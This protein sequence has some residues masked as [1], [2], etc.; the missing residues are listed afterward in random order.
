G[1]TEMRGH[2]VEYT[3]WNMDALFIPQ[4]HPARDLQDTFYLESKFK[5]EFEHPEILDIVSRSHERGVRSY[6]G[7]GY[8]FNLKEAQRLVLRTHT[9][10]STIRS[11]YENH[12]PPVAIFSVEKVFRHESVD[13]RHL[14]ELHQVEGAV[15]AK[16]ANLSTL[17]GLMRHFYHE[18]GFDDLEF[19]PSYYP[20]TEPSMDVVATLDEKEI[21]LGGS[22]IFRPEVTIPVG[23]KYPVIAWGLGL[24]RLAM[25][26]YGLK[27]IREIYN[28]DIDWLRNFQVRI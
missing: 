13:W 12:E 25:I 15:Y 27:D 21:E 23:L 28:S 2:Y 9:T 18:L 17:K 3:G 10:V 7:W 24:E 5:P 16:D 22:G 8:K 19:I 11:L 6:N 14:A 1:F 20:Y 26:L 4:D